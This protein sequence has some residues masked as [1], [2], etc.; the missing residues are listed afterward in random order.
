MGMCVLSQVTAP[1]NLNLK[2][3]EEGSQ[4][5]HRREVTKGIPGIATTLAIHEAAR[6]QC[7]WSN[8]CYA[9]DSSIEILFSN[10][11]SNMLVILSRFIHKFDFFSIQVS[12]K[13]AACPIA[14]L[15]FLPFFKKRGTLRMTT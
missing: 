14:Q 12:E 5:N 3:Q 10:T 6:S 9:Q 8:S 15:V 7:D 1:L 4:G 2:E 13:K 11:L